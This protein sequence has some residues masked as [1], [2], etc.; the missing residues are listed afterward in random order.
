MGSTGRR[1]IWRSTRLGG[2]SLPLCPTGERKENLSD[3]RE[4]LKRH[5]GRISSLL[6]PG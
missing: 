6:K 3:S 1:D 5:G 2:V 4:I